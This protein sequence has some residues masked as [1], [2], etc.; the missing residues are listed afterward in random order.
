MTQNN[1]IAEFR[2]NF[3]AERVSGGMIGAEADH[4]PELQDCRVG[5][6]RMHTC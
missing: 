6:S 3:V 5:S 2:A 1:E 4:A